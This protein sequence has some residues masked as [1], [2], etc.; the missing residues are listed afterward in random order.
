MKEI[1]HLSDL[2]NQ[3]NSYQVIKNEQISGDTDMVA[4]MSCISNK[5]TKISTNV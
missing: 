4:N 2:I 1:I 5:D 3:L